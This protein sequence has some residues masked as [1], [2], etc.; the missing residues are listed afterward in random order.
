MLRSWMMC[1]NL[2]KL[3]DSVLADV[4]RLNAD[5]RKR[6]RVHLTPSQK[7]QCE[8]KIV[9]M[10]Q[11]ESHYSAIYDA[12]FQSGLI[13]DKNS[14]EYNISSVVKL[15]NHV[16]KKHGLQRVPLHSKILALIHQGKDSKTIISTL[17]IT[18]RSYTQS[19]ERLQAKKL[20]KKKDY[21]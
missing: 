3:P 2:E 12:L 4:A 19:L 20:I 1:L 11:A 16:A 14:Q 18:R 8:K 6:I 9:E 10:L 21:M 17:Q 7:E 13:R 5:A 15:V